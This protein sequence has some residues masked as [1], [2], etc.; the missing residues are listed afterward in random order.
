MVPDQDGLTEH[1][2]RCS[3]IKRCSD[4]EDAV[5]A[6]SQPQQSDGFMFHIQQPHALTHLPTHLHSSSMTTP[7]SHTCDFTSV[8][9]IMSDWK[10]TPA[11]EHGTCSETQTGTLAF[12]TCQMVREENR[13][14]TLLAVGT[15]DTHALEKSFSGGST[16]PLTEN[17]QTCSAAV[18]G[19]R[20]LS[21]SI[22]NKSRP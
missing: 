12:Y 7:V 5:T 3:V 11:S 16:N 1:R 21:P 8:F 17:T 9:Q 19:H 10:L 6:P 13:S 20:E 22:G 2:R 14:R 18:P 15:S 4:H